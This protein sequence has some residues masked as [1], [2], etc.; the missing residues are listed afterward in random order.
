MKTLRYPVLYYTLSENAVRALLLGTPLQIVDSS[1]RD[2]RKNISEYLQKQYK[3]YGDY[4]EANLL[5]ARLKVF[6]VSVKPTY[7]SERGVF[8]VSGEIAVPVP[9]VYGQSEYG[10]WEC[11]LPSL[12]ERFSFDRLDEL[13]SLAT[14]FARNILNQLPPNELHNHL[15]NA[16][17]E[18]GFIN[19]RINEDRFYE[20]SYEY[21]HQFEVLEKLLAPFPGSKKNK[22]QGFSY[23]DAAWEREEIV[24]ELVHKVGANQANILLV[25][26][27]GTGKTA[28]LNQTIKKITQQKKKQKLPF[29]CWQLQAQRITAGSKYLGEW[30]EKVEV[31]IEELSIVHGLL[32]VEDVIQ[33]LQ[34]GGSGVEG[35]VAAYLVHFLNEGKVQII[36]EAS[37]EELD[38]IQRLLP[39]FAEHFQT[40][41]LP[42]L[43]ELKVKSILSAFSEFSS[44]NWGIK[45]DQNAQDFVFRLMVRYFPYESFP[46]KAITFLGECIFEAQQNHY[47]RIN[48]KRVLEQIIKQTGLPEMLIRDE[49]LLDMKEVRGFFEGQII[50]QEA[51]VDKLCEVVKVFK[52]GLNDPNKPI[53]TMLFAGPTGVGKTASA[54]ALADYFFGEGQRKNPLVRIDMS[55][56]QYP[57]QIDRIIGANSE[58]SKLVQE[59]RERPFSVLLL[60][61]IEKAHPAIYDVLL[62][63]LDEGVL[64]DAYGRVTN[65]RNTVIIITTNLGASNRKAIG[66]VDKEAEDARYN[67]A[68]NFFFRPEFV[69]RI[70]GIVLFKSLEEDSIQKIAL[71]E[72]Q[73]LNEREGIQKRNLKLEFTEALQ[74]YVCSKGFDIRFG[75][76]P[77]QRAIED[78]VVY[79]FSRWLLKNQNVT[80]RKL[81]LDYHN[82]MRLTVNG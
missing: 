82:Y 46:G 11:F 73:G 22:K 7:R 59:I 6:Q 60:D 38:S 67:A 14:Y 13:E 24:E 4:E 71:K 53:S 61:E 44:R 49:L 20:W 50:G 28:V 34:T 32:W 25:G 55:E 80:D 36:A 75:A 29:S 43:S 15:T 31:M 41:L 9:T 26:G 45:V 17:P 33:L 16:L 5:E 12:E 47:K 51:V 56:F 70:D 62:N 54:K 21:Q 3:K 30:Q 65:F 78:D 27:K 57:Y 19:M 37:P 52:T 18:L 64:T 42:E 48:K 68:I 74:Q 40:V 10:Y 2:A 72:L 39:G 81:L 69:N 63:L 66:F 35:S 23:P 58:V 77:L 8:P 1:K 76:R 79:P